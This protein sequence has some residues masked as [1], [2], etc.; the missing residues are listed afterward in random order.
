MSEAVSVAR[1]GAPAGR[2]RFS[3]GAGVDWA[4]AAWPDKSGQA[5]GS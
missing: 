4:F 3:A 2:L 1:G 5:Y